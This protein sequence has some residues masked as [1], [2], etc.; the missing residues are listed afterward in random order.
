MR[1]SEAFLR[2]SRTNAGH[3]FCSS[4]RKRVQ[5]AKMSNF[6]FLDWKR[7]K[8]FV[9]FHFLSYGAVLP[10]QPRLCYEWISE[11]EDMAQ[12]FLQM[13]SFR[14]REDLQLCGTHYMMPSVT[15]SQASDP[16]LRFHRD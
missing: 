4:H 8:L 12:R 6:L 5:T 7:C 15:T 2:Q 9:L 13:R 3:R 10:H 1:N 16:D 11:S 14:S